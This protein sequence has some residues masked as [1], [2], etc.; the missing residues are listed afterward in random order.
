MRASLSNS[1][2]S[3]LEEQKTNQLATRSNDDE[4]VRRPKLDENSDPR[5]NK[6]SKSRP[7]RNQTRKRVIVESESSSDFSLDD[8][9]E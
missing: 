3:D 7:P 1:N 5:T 9:E 8:D 6:P 4:D 2:G